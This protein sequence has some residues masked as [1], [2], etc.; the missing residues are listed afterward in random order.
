MK[1][2]NGF[3]VSGTASINIEAVKDLSKDD[4]FEM[5]KGKLA[6]DFELVYSE[7]Q[8]N[9]IDESISKPSKQAKKS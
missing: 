6:D 5:V 1:I 7:I 4:F 8:K 9:N 3:L 2:E